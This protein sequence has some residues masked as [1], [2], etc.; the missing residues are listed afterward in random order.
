MDH[1]TTD[2]KVIFGL[3]VSDWTKA[4]G[5]ILVV[6][7]VLSIA[8]AFSGFKNSPALA[9]LAQAFDSSTSALA[10]ATG[11]WYLFLAAFMIS[12]FVPAASKWLAEKIGKTI[13]AGKSEPAVKGLTDAAIIEK[14]TELLSEKQDPASRERAAEAVAEAEKSWDGQSEEERKESEE[15]C[16]EAHVEIPAKSRIRFVNIRR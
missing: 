15:A 10:W 4:I 3:T 2:S 1:P 11:H 7:I 16:R 8:N 9:N 6:A 12:P 14:K 5:I 13:K